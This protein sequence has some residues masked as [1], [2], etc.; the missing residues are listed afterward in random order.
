MNFFAERIERLDVH[1]N[2][3][4]VRLFEEARRR[5]READAALARGELWGPLHG[6]PMTIKEFFCIEGVLTT[7]GNKDFQD[8]KP[9]MNAVVVDKLLG[10]GAIIIGK[11]NVPKNGLDSQSYND[12]YGTS[13]N[14]WNVEYSPGGSSGGSAGALAAGF[15][16][17]EVGSDIGGSIRG[18]AHCCGVMGLK[19]T[20]G[21][22]DSTGH[23]P[24]AR[25]Y[26][27]PSNLYVVGPMARCCSDL[28]L[29][30]DILAG[31]SKYLEEAWSL[32]LPPPPFNLTSQLRVAVCTGDEGK[33]SFKSSSVEPDVAR[34]IREAGEALARAG[35]SVNFDAFPDIKLEETF[36]SHFKLTQAEEAGWGATIPYGDYLRNENKRWIVR[37]A[38]AEFFKSYDVFLCPVARTTAIKHDHSEP[39]EDRMI[40]VIGTDTPQPYRTWHLWNMLIIY[41]ALPVT[42]VPVGKSSNGLPIG[43][44]I[45]GNAFHDR[46]TIRVG[47]ILEKVHRGFEAPNLDASKL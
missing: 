4:V 36:K 40:P 38:W 29:A 19:P 25:Y 8:Y 47:S 27:S 2:L 37:E 32:R 3:V 33:G 13:K 39:I 23:G 46:T 20:L 45:V 18:P 24:F 42:V 26:M 22:I 17:L 30:L 16:P 34:S 6:V 7:M 15:A 44:Q 21:V 14:P 43:V 12:I 11:T 1:F 9:K 31:P 35:A 41:A 5:A 10:A 28:E